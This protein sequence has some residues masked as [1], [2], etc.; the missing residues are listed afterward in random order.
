MDLVK[1][2]EKLRILKVFWKWEVLV[3]RSGYVQISSAV[4]YRGFPRQLTAAGFQKTSVA[5]C[6]RAFSYFTRV[7]QPNNMWHSQTTCGNSN[8]Q[9]FMYIIISSVALQVCKHPAAIA[10]WSP[11]QKLSLTE[12]YVWRKKNGNRHKI[13]TVQI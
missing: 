3:L 13:D 12:N 9:A 10:K 8:T 7:A 1:I 4:N 11:E 6:R 2:G 5:N